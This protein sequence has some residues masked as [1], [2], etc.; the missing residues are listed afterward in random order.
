MNLDVNDLIEP[1]LNGIDNALSKINKI[2]I[3]RVEKVEEKTIDLQ[4][5]FKGKFDGKEYEMPLLTKVP[6][7]FLQGGGSYRAD[8]ISV[9]DYALIFISDRCIENWYNGKDNQVPRQYRI[10]S[11]SD[12]FAIVGINP[13]ATA[14]TIPTVITE[15]GNK[16]K[17]GN[18]EHLGDITHTGLY[19]QEGNF[20]RNGDLTNNGNEITNGNKTINGILAVNGASGGSTSNVSNTNLAFDGSSDITIAGVSL[21]DFINNHTHT[22]ST[23]GAESSTPN[24]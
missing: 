22:S 9:G 14:L 6:P 7:I 3:A 23:A 13:I 17:N 8:P 10:H 15:I 24:L 2:T 19:T 12:A 4:P 11:L 18:C 16:Y 21:T 1:I 5:V 20:V